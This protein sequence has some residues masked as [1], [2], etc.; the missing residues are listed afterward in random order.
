[1]AYQY[2]AGTRRG[3][4]LISGKVVVSRVSRVPY[5]QNVY[6][7][8][9]IEPGV[10]PDAAR[11]IAEHEAQHGPLPASVREWY[12]VPNVAPLDWNGARGSHVDSPHIW[13]RFSGSA[14]PEPLA[15]L[16]SDGTWEWSERQTFP[17]A[18]IMRANQDDARWWVGVD[19][20][21]D[22]PVWL[23][24]DFEPQEAWDRVAD[25]FSGFLFERIDGHYHVRGRPSSP[26]ASGTQPHSNGLW[27]RSRDEPFQPPV[28]DFL[29]DHFGEP[30]RAP[31]AGEVTSYIFRPAGGTI[32]VTADEPA[33]TGGLSA[34]WVH[35]DTAERLAE[36]ARLLLPWG[37]LRDTFR[38]DTDPARAVLQSLRT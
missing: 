22:P 18:V 36:F 38:A 14:Y 20:S 7:L 2:V 11:M 33:L 19:G 1:M 25:T 30:E 8:L 34:W 35:A 24:F 16:L 23:E 32:R 3:F 17:C 29:T 12:L 10:C 37:T 4:D 21:D 28:I 13:K 27:L 6:D 26:V 5:H 15:E 31:H 9:G